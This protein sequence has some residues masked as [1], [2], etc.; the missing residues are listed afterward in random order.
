MRKLSL[1][2]AVTALSCAIVS[3]VGAGAQAPDPIAVPG[4]TAADLLSPD[5][6][7]FAQDGGSRMTVPVSVD[8]KGPY[9]FL[10]DT[11]AERTVISR[12]LA[13]HLALVPGR[14]VMM[15]SMTEVGRVDTAVIPR[16]DVSKKTVTDI[17]APALAAANLGAAGM[18]GVDTLQAQRVIFD[19]QKKTMSIVASRKPQQTWGPDT[20]VVRGR[21]MFGRLVL[22]DADVEGEKILVILDTGSQVSIGNEALR[23]RL[24][25]KKKLGAT[26][27]VQLTSV[28]GGKVTADYTTVRSIK[29]GGVR[30]ENMPIGFA[31]VHPFRQL[32]LLDKPAFLLG[33]D[34]LE[35]FDRVSVDFARREVRIL[36]PD[37]SQRSSTTRMAHARRKAPAAI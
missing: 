26:F 16:L 12:E 8:G 32:K 17:H 5:V 30:V 19:F 25:S 4:I 13:R 2:K 14:S 15:H 35:L 29:I 10:V 21:S 23:R 34:V 27:P 22:V 3:Q 33:M 1:L 24:A 18:L 7:G 31:D 9:R 20:I 36:L 28:T 6:M 11:G 37:S